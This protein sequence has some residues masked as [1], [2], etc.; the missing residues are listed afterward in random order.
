MCLKNVSRFVL[1][2]ANSVSNFFIWT[3]KLMQFKASLPNLSF[4]SCSVLEREHLEL[5]LVL[6]E[7]MKLDWLSSSFE[8]IKTEKN[9]MAPKIL[10]FEYLI[11]LYCLNT[12]K[13]VVTFFPDDFLFF[14]FGAAFP[15]DFHNPLKKSA[16]QMCVSSTSLFATKNSFIFRL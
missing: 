12:Y 1:C 13:R 11:K 4:V 10:W 8:W 15:R 6:N 5:L 9:I 2:T 16:K 3:W 7:C 14:F